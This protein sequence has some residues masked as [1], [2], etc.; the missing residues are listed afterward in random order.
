MCFIKK[1]QQKF[2]G[3]MFGPICQ[4]CFTQRAFTSQ[5]LLGIWKMNNIDDINLC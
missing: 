4:S 1:V 2:E 5:W 3:I